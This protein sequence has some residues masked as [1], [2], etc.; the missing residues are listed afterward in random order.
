MTEQ[1]LHLFDTYESTKHGE[2]VL[3]DIGIYDGIKSYHFFSLGYNEHLYWGKKQLKS[4]LKEF[5]FED[6]R[7]KKDWVKPT[8]MEA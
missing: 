8:T 1:D 4:N 3:R 6:T 5:E 2:V 7:K